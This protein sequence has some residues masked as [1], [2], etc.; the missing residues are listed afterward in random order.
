MDKKVFVEKELNSIMTIANPDIAWLEYIVNDMGE[1]VIVTMN[2]N[3]HYKI[4]VTADSLNA[5]IADVIN[6][7][8][9]K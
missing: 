9:W 1:F 7:M 6:Y 8:K 3:C 5:L 4:D 2:N